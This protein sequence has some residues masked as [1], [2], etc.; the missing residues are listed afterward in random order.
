MGIREEIQNA[1]RAI[2][3]RQEQLYDDLAWEA[4][5]EIAS[6]YPAY[7]AEEIEAA[8]RGESLPDR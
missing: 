1:E 7:T 3:R 8:L 2:E 5:M 6:R 4:G